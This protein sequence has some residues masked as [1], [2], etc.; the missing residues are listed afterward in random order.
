MGKARR[1]RQ[2][3]GA[4]PPVIVAVDHGRRIPAPGLDDLGRVIASLVAAD[5]DGLMLTGAMAV[6]FDRQ[7]GTARIVMSVSVDHPLARVA[8]EQA[9]VLAADAVKYEVFPM[10]S[11][12]RLTYRALEGLAAECERLGMPLMAEVV[13]GGFED[14][15]AQHALAVAQ[16]VRMAAEAGA[17][18]VKVP[19]PVDG[20]L[21]PVTASATVPVLLLGGPTSDRGSLEDDVRRGA[22]QGA[23]GVVVGRRIWE[24]RDPGL[25][26]ARLR[27]ALEEGNTSTS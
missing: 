9:L 4:R 20:T 17:D 12:E 24:S 10:T 13:P 26:I 25:A 2:L 8:V 6:R 23:V 18:L 27:S 16:G 15:A 22:S 5:A 19:F 1:L 7:C 11:E 14:R 21:Q 3:L